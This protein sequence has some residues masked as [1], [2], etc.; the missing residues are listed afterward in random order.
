MIPGLNDHELDNILEAAAA[1]GAR[2]AGTILIRLPLEIADLFREWLEEHYPDRAARVLKLIRETRG[3]ELY[4]SSF[5]IR[6]RG[7]GPYAELLARRF[8]L[9][10][11]RHG[12]DRRL[13]ALDTSQFVRPAQRG[14]LPLF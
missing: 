3:G 2:S 9:A 4:E 6:M 7:R 14:Q 11:A 12:L 1:A 13:P 10:A 8:Q 5:G